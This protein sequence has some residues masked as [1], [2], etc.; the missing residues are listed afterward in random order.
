M[1]LFRR[2]K[3]TDEAQLGEQ[4]AFEWM[5]VDEALAY[6]KGEKKLTDDALEGMA[7][8]LC[9]QLKFLKEQQEGTKEEFTQVTQ[10]IA[11][12]Q[13]LEQMSESERAEVMDAARMVVS[14]DEERLRYQKGNKLLTLSQY[15]MMER[16]EDEFP[17][18]IEE[19]AR[20]EQYLELVREDMHKLESEK[21]S[22]LY[23][24]ENAS[25]KR[26]FLN[27]FS[28]GVIITALA[29]FIV[30][31]VLADNTGRDMSVPFF[32]TGIAAVGYI[33]YYAY[34][35]GQCGTAVKRSEYMLNRAT[36]L[37]NKVKI[38]YVNT[39]NVLDYSYEKYN[40]N[41]LNELRYI[42]ENYLRTK[43]EEKKY[44]KNVQ[45]LSA[46]TDKLELALKWIGIEKPDAWIHQA[47][48]LLSR[49]ELADFKDAVSKRRNK[50]RAQIDYNIRQQDGTRNEL[51]TLKRKYAG[52]EHI[53]ISQM[54]KAGLDD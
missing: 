26:N 25:A 37:L 45:L 5:T 18:R 54:Q 36:T 10:Y 8:E 28:Y 51:E 34:A 52:R 31:I 6:T 43:E 33:F 3:K 7:G 12:V 41:S 24:S 4:L 9:E 30:L 39:T 46:Y 17:Q 40:V 35:A 15:H 13:R 27:K 44:R 16:Y 1:G 47:E 19:L 11:D 50:L 14:L 42:W 20:Q 49:A 22:I 29:V 38:K 32:L 23:D 2:R 48:I 53:I 21:G